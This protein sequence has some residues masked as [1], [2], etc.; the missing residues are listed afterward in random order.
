[1]P[2]I[3]GIVLCFL[4]VAL[5]L[6]ADGAAS[7]TASARV[8]TE[9][10]GGTVRYGVAVENTGTQGEIVSVLIGHNRGLTE[11]PSGLGKPKGWS[12]RIVKQELPG[13]GSQWQLWLSCDPTL[14]VPGEPGA[15]STPT[16]PAAT[17]PCQGHAI[18]PGQTQ[19][20]TLSVSSQRARRLERESV[21]LVFANGKTETA[22]E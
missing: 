7:N 17:D 22:R 13:G 14:L 19:S 11:K 15:P 2:G 8:T 18:R 20:F 4:S 5:Q 21:M 12:H 16:D 1:M 9:I 10:S 3:T 6:P